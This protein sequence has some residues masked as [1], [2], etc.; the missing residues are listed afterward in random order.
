MKTLQK[1][2]FDIRISKLPFNFRAAFRIHSLEQKNIRVYTKYK[3]TFAT[4]N[5]SGPTNLKEAKEGKNNQKTNEKT[6]IPDN[7]NI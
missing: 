4:P 7:K 3:S 6:K 1:N 2:A 5:K